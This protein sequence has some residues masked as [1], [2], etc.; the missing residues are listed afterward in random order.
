MVRFGLKIFFLLFLICCFLPMSLSAKESTNPSDHI[1]FSDPIIINPKII[2]KNL[3][4][5]LFVE[6]SKSRTAEFIQNR[7]K[8]IR[9]VYAVVM[10]PYTFEDEK[11]EAQG[12]SIDLLRLWSKK[13]GIPIEFKS[14]VWGETLQT[15]RDD[16]ADIHASLNYTEER[17]TYLDFAANVAATQGTIFYHK[18]IINIHEPDDLTG[19]R[20]GVVQGGYY[21]GY[22]RENLPQASMVS[23]VEFPQ[24]VDA[25]EKGE[26]YVFIDELHAS[27][28][29]LKEKGLVDKFSYIPETAI[30]PNN[31]WI[32]AREG[33]KDLVN[34]LKQGMALIT[35]EERA[36]LERKWLTISTVKTDDTLFISMYN[37][38]APYSFVNAEGQPAGLFVDIWNLWAEKTGKKIAFLTSNWSNSLS[39]LKKGTAKIHSGLFY[40]DSR[41]AWI[42]YSQPFYE[43]GSHIFYSTRK[44]APYKDGRYI[45]KEIGA[46]K[47]SYYEEHLRIKHPTVDV[48]TF[49]GM[50]KMLR[51]TLSGDIDGCL[52]EYLSGTAMINRLGLSGLFNSTESI[53]LRQKL[54]AGV[55]KD[56]TQL[57]SLVEKGFEAITDKELLEIEQRWVLD[58]DKQFFRSSAKR[59]TLTD[60]EKAWLKAHPD[61]TL[62]YTDVFEPE[63]IVSPDGSYRGI[64]VDILEELN[65]RLGT[66]IRLQIDPIPQ[67]IEKMLGK[68]IDGILS[69]H[70]GYADK[71]GLLKTGSYIP[72][73][74]AVFARKDIFFN[75]PSDFDG[76]KVAIIDKVFFSEQIMAQQ[77]K[78]A[79]ILK[80]KDTEEGLRLLENGQAEFFLGATL[81]LY[82]INKYQLPNLALQYV[83][84]HEPLNSVMATRSDW[85][86][87]SA[88]IDKGMASFSKEE[89]EAIVSRWVS[90]PVRARSLELTGD[91]IAWLSLHPTIRLGIDS[92][93]EPAVFVKSDGSIEGFDPDLIDR[94][95]EITGANISLVHGRWHELVEEAKKKEIDGLAQSAAINERAEFFS[96]T[97]SYISQYYGLAVS[98]V[99]G[100]SIK[101]LSDL[102]GKKLTVEKGN[103]WVHKLIGKLKGVQ[104]VDVESQDEAFKFV[105]EGK[106]DAAVI[107]TTKYSQLSKIYKES[108]K[109]V[110]VFNENRIDLVY[111]IRNDWPELVSIVNKA[112]S[113]IGESGKN[114]LRE[115]WYG[116]SPPRQRKIIEL[117]PEEQA[118]LAQHH[119]IRVTFSDHAPYCYLEDGKVVG[120][121]LD[122]LKRIS[123]ITGIKFQ[124]ENKL[125]KW[126]DELEGFKNRTGP[127]LLPSIR[128]TPEREKVMLFTEPYMNSSMFIFTR[129]D[130]PFF[131]SLENLFGKKVAVIRNYVI[132]AHL[133]ENNPK[134]DLLVV[135]TVEEALR[136]VSK[137][138][139]DAFLGDMISIPFLINK[140]GL[141]NLKAACPSGLPDH[142]LAMG[143]RSDWPELRNIL[144]KALE[145]IT[146]DEKAAIINR[147]Q[148]V[149]I[150]HGIRRADIFKWGLI[151]SGSVLFV[152]LLFAGWNLTLNRKVKARTFELSE[153]KENLVNAQK[154]AHVGDWSW[155]IMAD[156]ITW[157]DELYRIYGVEPDTTLTYD[158]LME[159]IHPEDRDYHNNHASEWLKNKGGDPYQY[160]IIR[161]DGSIRHIYA[162]GKVECND[163]GEPVRMLGTTQDI[164]K[165]MLDQE[166]IR[167][168][169]SFTDHLIQTANVMII[170]LDKKGQVTH[171]NPAAEKISGYKLSEIEGE[172][173]FELFTPIEKY[174]QVHAEFNRLLAGGLPKRFDNPILTKKGDERFISWVNS[175]IMEDGA[176]VG[177]ISFGLDIT[178][179][180]QSEQKLYNYQQRLKAL[181]SQLTVAEE[182]ERRRIA[183]DLHDSVGQS[184]ALSRMQISV[185]Q[186]KIKDLDSLEILNEISETLKASI[187]DTR[188]LV[189]ELSSPL[190]NEIGL[191]DAIA[192][193]LEE[194]I[195]KRHGI[196]TELIV[197]GEKKRLDDDL[198]ALL[199]R[200][201]RELLTN[202][203]KHAK[204]SQLKVVFEFT[205]KDLKV[206][207]TDDGIGYDIA[208]A[209]EQSYKENS[210]GLFS[211]EE[212]MND[213]GGSFEISSEPGKGTTAV[214]MVPR[215]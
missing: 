87:F 64:M 57:H 183:A 82:L 122:Y 96:F 157:S 104:I 190:M 211:I 5:S 56:D 51:A 25:A 93:W 138:T 141:K 105:V 116:L 120:I 106:A 84:Y 53:H 162:V 140:F 22:I 198:R 136:A 119:T 31:F 200:N 207:V 91:E 15:M 4:S 172:N 121:I 36:G 35:P 179:Q 180:K 191:T 70:P 146:A 154:L 44:E 171:F 7:T 127:G 208:E 176:S 115:K 209:V 137:G 151:V 199:F 187:Q 90:I 61:I 131:S 166:K 14:A 188:H 203:V 107:G 83:F 204:A 156:K 89:I 26:I 9:I 23:Y 189:F 158:S 33:D 110:H 125:Y 74:P 101:K 161:P 78:N 76:K 62:G 47:D 86:E 81:S 173:W 63:V 102:T 143:I 114:T 215:R 65:S 48:I 117:T 174:P 202:V 124:H 40:S 32:A 178:E 8:P 17:D 46:I 155:D 128:P 79:T 201:I 27:L 152:L 139:V 67:V 13:T 55:L 88:I 20:V 175:E 113:Y 28:Y 103:L 37:D 94:I 153:S 148:T 11:G 68:E 169:H 100:D 108:I 45:K 39:N 71:L 164:T 52:V 111:S 59:I 69:L 54:Y 118:W 177:T 6:E 126:A 30:Y 2:S 205:E 3:E 18:N 182:R 185:V 192:D 130:A 165:R 210:F 167:Q 41:A 144:D 194:E 168:M 149:R 58:Q 135:D 109:M 50:E 16:Q 98:H 97:E 129:N 10:A 73:Y 145:A 133:S 163:K 193:W 212:R 112:L 72:S 77:G 159:M 38:F 213:L 85:P 160:R 181:V 99:Q 170:G 195:E 147:W 43:T 34:A 60:A 134:I 150:E 80:V 66:G 92:Q 49:E 132:H 12:F 186:K 21:V 123:E 1:I 75:H 24:M 214:L 142:P 42:D 197:K 29:R 19:Y 196:K 95:N 206:M 184:L